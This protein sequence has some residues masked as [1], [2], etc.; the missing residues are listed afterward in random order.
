LL[1]FKNSLCVLDNSLLSDMSSQIFSPICGLSSHS[2][3]K[4]YIIM[5]I[6]NA[7]LSL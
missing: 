4:T 2:V 1:S 7:F 3:G 6:V 5:S